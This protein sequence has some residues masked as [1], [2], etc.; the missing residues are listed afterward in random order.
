MVLLIG[1][2]SGGSCVSVGI[3]VGSVRM[4]RKVR[5]LCM[6]FFR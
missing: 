5:I 3:V 2:F 1:L 6:V 4:V